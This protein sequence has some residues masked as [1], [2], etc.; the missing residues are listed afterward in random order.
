VEDKLRRLA[1][2]RIDRARLERLLDFVWHLEAQP[3][4]AACMP[5]L[6]VQS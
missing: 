3:D 5:L 1:S 2:R 4:M 6:R